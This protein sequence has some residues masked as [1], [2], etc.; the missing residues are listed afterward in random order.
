MFYK[1]QYSKW[2]NSKVVDAETK[3]ELMAIQ[4]D[5]SELKNRFSSM[6]DFGTAGLRGI[7][8]AGLNQMNIYTVR[9]AT[10]ALSELILKTGAEGARK[11]VCIA[12]DSRLFSE[13]FAWEAACTFSANGIFVY[14]FDELRPTPELSYAIRELGA[15]AGINITASHNP[16]EYNGYKV[17]WDDG[18]Q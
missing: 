12:Y 16:K 10:Q 7:V 5:D 11:G 1:K 15:I 13:E 14:I 18:E 3:K 6:L 8:G 2:M 17:Y 9:Y 4:D